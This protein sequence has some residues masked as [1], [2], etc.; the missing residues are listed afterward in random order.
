M[1]DSPIN[2]YESPQEASLPPPPSA[3][4][5]LM[6]RLRGP[7]IGLL[8]LSGLQAGYMVA[9][10]V[11]LLIMAAYEPR[12][13]RQMHPEDVLTG[14]GAFVP[15][16]FIFYGAWQMRRMRSLKVSRAAAIVACIP[17]LS[18]LVCVGIP[19]G[20]WAAVVLFMKSTAVHFDRR[21]PE[22]ID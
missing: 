3:R 22:L 12:M 17:F 16:A 13:W 21:P 2:P 15:S 8:V 4:T 18:P 19:L 10:G 14:I 9:A 5:Q 11:A 6:W 7:S 20:I 1:S